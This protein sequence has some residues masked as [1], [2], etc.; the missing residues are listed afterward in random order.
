MLT[1][2]DKQVRCTVVVTIAMFVV[3]GTQTGQSA[4]PVGIATARFLGE[5]NEWQKASIIVY[6]A[7]P[8]FGAQ[9]YYI[10]GEGRLI[11]VSVKMEPGQG[12]VELRHELLIAVSIVESLI[13]KL[14]E[15]DVL[16]AGL[17]ALDTPPRTCIGAPLLILR[18]SKGVLRSVPFPRARP[19]AAY[20]EAWL[21]VSALKDVVA[22]AHAQFSGDYEPTFI[23]KGFEWSSTV[24]GPRKDINFSRVPTAEE[25]ARAEEESWRAVELQIREVEKVAKEKQAAED[26]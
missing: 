16:T 19:T 7:S 21:K 15:G 9:E 5:R 13:D 20:E 25:R 18:N 12:A 3:V 8:L 26:R 23:P 2:F 22:D 24:L 10:T 14:V 17:A 1:F 4:E 11:S 6:Q